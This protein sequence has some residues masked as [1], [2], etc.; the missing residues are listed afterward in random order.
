MVVSM[1]I[2]AIHFF[3]GLRGTPFLPAGSAEE[4]ARAS[5][6]AGAR[7]FLV[8]DADYEPAAPGVADPVRRQHD[9]LEEYL[10]APD[11]ELV[12]RNP[13]EGVKVHTLRRA[14]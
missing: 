5:R 8:R 13:D 10:E 9:R 14:P 1:D 6:A 12:Y 2:P 3:T 7:Y 11:F 4:F